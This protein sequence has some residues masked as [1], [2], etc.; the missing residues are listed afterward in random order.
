LEVSALLD[1]AA[2]DDAVVEALAAKGNPAIRKREAAGEA[3]GKAEAILSVL[4]SRGLAV[5]ADQRQEI[6][7]CADLACLDRWPRRAALAAST[8]EVIASS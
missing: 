8:A 7:R 6:L 1:A 2:A 3:R 4:E 5:S